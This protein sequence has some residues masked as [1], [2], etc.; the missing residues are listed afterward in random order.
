MFFKNKKSV[1]MNSNRIEYPVYDNGYIYFGYY[2]QDITKN[3][4]ENHKKSV[5]NFQKPGLT[6]EQVLELRKIRYNEKTHKLETDNSKLRDF[7][8]KEILFS[9]GIKACENKEY[10]FMVKSIRWKILFESDDFW[11]VISEKIL[12]NLQFANDRENINYEDSYIRKWLNEVFINEAFSEEEQKFLCPCSL[13]LGPESTDIFYTSYISAGGG[14]SYPIDKNIYKNIYKSNIIEDKV[15][16]L[17]YQDLI[18]ASF[19][20]NTNDENSEVRQRYYTDYCICQNINTLHSTADYW[21]K[22]KYDNVQGVFYVNKDGNIQ[23]YAHNYN[24][25]IVQKLGVV[26]AIAISKV[27]NK[28]TKHVF[29][30]NLPSGVSFSKNME[31]ILVNYQ[32]I[33]FGKF[34]QEDNNDKTPIMWNVL[35][36]TEDYFL[37]QSRYILDQKIFDEGSNTFEKS[38]IRKWLNTKFMEDVFTNEEKNM[39]LPVFDDDKITILSNDELRLNKYKFGILDSGTFTREKIA[40]KYAIEKGLYDPKYIFRNVPEFESWYWTRS[41]YYTDL[42]KTEIDTERA[43]T[44][45]EKGALLPRKKNDVLCGVVP[46]IKLRK[47]SGIQLLTESEP[48]RKPKITI[49][50]Q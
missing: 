23:N 1:K 45:N 25:E 42:Y 5:Y 30:Y 46:V 11:F 35:E 20:F 21:T 13:N 32:Y 7:E 47:T 39:L 48:E 6:L 8:N 10:L 37:L 22:S 44:V 17:S 2:P 14:S 29:S 43:Y 3:K 15:F 16:I 27:K 24:G 9:N 41:P 26:P 12:D 34:Y 4:I 40:T 50:F 19:R 28:I 36:E 18:N 31:D 49:S 38:S 33:M